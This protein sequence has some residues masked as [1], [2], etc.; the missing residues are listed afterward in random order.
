MFAAD[1]ETVNSPYGLRG[2]SA[3]DIEYFPGT[4]YWR[5]P[6][7]ISVNYLVLRGLYKYYYDYT[8]LYPLSDDGNI[9]TVKDLYKSIR[10]KLVQVV[11]DN[12]EPQ[13]LLYENFND[14][15]G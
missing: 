7:W 9:K 5:G 15:T 12:W 8:P 6:I 2:V 3:Q 1:P 10:Q 14:V 13:H 4:G 11:Y